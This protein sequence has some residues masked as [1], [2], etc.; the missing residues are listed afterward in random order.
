MKM[1][2]IREMKDEDLKRKLRELRLEL[3]KE[4]ANVR[5]GRPIKNP[6]KIRV[7]R[8]TIARILTVLRERSGGKK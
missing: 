4:M 5:M 6:G 3:M 2:E 7:L 1:K 8:K